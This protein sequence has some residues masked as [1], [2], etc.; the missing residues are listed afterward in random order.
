[1]TMLEIAAI[2]VFAVYVGGAVS[3]FVW[4]LVKLGT[5]HIGENILGSIIWP[6]LAI[7]KAIKK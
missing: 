6:W 5:Q 3:L 1:M 4:S 7:K 2:A